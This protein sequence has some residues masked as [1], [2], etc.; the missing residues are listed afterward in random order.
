MLELSKT[1]IDFNERPGFSLN[2]GFL[3]IKT[4]ALLSFQNYHFFWEL[5]T[6]I[7]YSFSCKFD[8]WFDFKFLNSWRLWRVLLKELFENF[9]VSESSLAGGLKDLLSLPE[10]FAKY[11]IPPSPFLLASFKKMF[12]GEKIKREGILSIRFF[13][14]VTGFFS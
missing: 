1:S 2:V 13:L 6:L 7:L 14:P 11:P 9:T 8:S 5:S 10:N 4:F 3:P 12:L